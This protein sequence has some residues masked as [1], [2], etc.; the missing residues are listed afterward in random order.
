MKIKKLNKYVW[1]IGLLLLSVTM[2]ISGIG[3]NSGGGS[4]SNLAKKNISR[5]G[6]AASNNTGRSRIPAGT[7]GSG[8]S[9]T[10]YDNGEIYV[11]N[12]SSNSITV[13]SRTASGN[14]APLRTIS[15]TTTGLYRPGGI[16]VDTV[17]NEI[18]IVNGSDNYYNNSITVYSRTASGNVAPLR[19]ISGTTTG[20]NSPNGIAVDTVNNEIDVANHYGPVTVYARTASGNVMPLRIFYPGIFS[21]MKSF[22]GIAVDPVNNEIY[23]T[24]NVNGMGIP[25]QTAI[26]VY[27]RTASGNVAPLRTISGTT[28]GLDWPWGIAVDTVNNQIDCSSAQSS[29]STGCML[30]GAVDCNNG[31]YCLSGTMCAQSGGQTMCYTGF[32]AATCSD[33]SCC[34]SGYTCAP[35]GGCMPSS[36]V[37]CG[38][39]YCCPSGATCAQSG[40]KTVC[41]SGT[42]G[43]TCSDGSCCPSGD[44][45]ASIGCIPT[46]AIDCSNGYYCPS[47]TTCGQAI[48]TSGQTKTVCNGG[49]G[50]VA[51]SDGTY[52]Y[53]PSGDTCAYAG[54]CIPSGTVDCNNGYYC[55]AGTTCSPTTNGQTVCN[56][57]APRYSCSGSSCVSDPNGSYT[58]SNCNNACGGGGGGS[59]CSS[60]SDCSAFGT[61]CCS[62]RSNAFCESDHL[63]HCCEVLCGGVSGNCY[64]NP[65]CSSS[66]GCP[67]V[68]DVCWESACTFPL[69]GAP[70]NLTC[71]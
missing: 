22:W 1:F 39:G 5:I 61:N 42:C 19:T 25:Y 43:T 71:Q 37:D 56:P 30:A 46:G 31:Y 65:S 16:T 68:G 60:D 50:S 9:A 8:F 67:T 69:G 26:I 7:P 41:D 63:C 36:A 14:V 45:C 21:Y 55:S 29:A 49:A 57:V 33:G 66:S 24:D 64:C 17:N 10:C 15:G 23:I 54:G 18:D 40:G 6:G 20:L 62:G 47:G 32:C 2:S 34:P 13:Y 27:P 58:A 3:C 51:C 48:F 28:T 12:Q 52:T 11:A 35:K 70:N 53:C 44:T 59:T 4:G 38:N